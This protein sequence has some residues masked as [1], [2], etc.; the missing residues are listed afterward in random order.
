MLISL[1]IGNIFDNSQS[2]SKLVEDFD[3][4]HRYFP[5]KCHIPP[6]GNSQKEEF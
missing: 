2:Q 6:L 4:F 5:C 3:R 1:E